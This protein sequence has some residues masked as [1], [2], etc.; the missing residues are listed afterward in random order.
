MKNNQSSNNTVFTKEE[1]E[2]IHK[3]NDKLNNYEYV[4]KNISEENYFNIIQTG[5]EIYKFSVIL[6][7]KKC[8]VTDRFDSQTLFGTDVPFEYQFKFD[9]IKNIGDRINKNHK[10]AFKQIYE[11]LECFDCFLTWFENYSKNKFNREIKIKNCH[12][13]IQSFLKPQTSKQDIIYINKI[14]NSLQNLKEYIDLMPNGNY[15]LPVIEGYRLLELMIEFYLKKEGYSVTDGFVQE[16]NYKLPI[17]QFCNKKNIFPRDFQSYFTL[18]Y[19]YRNEFVHLN[20]TC[21]LSLEFLKALNYIILWFNNTFTEK[22]HI[23]KPFNIYDC[24]FKISSLPKSYED[25]ITKPL[26]KKIND[27]KL[28]VNN[29]KKVFYC[30]G[31]SKNEQIYY[32]DNDELLIE[33][34]TEKIDKMQLQLDNLERKNSNME[35]QINKMELQINN[36]TYQINTCQSLIEKQINNAVSEDE[37]DRLI[38]A[39]VDECSNKILKFT[40][41][42]TEEKTYEIEKR[43]L[44]G[45]LGKNAWNKMSDNSKSFLISSKI[46]YNELI[47]IDEIIDYSGVCIL[48]TKALEFEIFKRF[49]TNFLNYLNENYNHDYSQY[50]TALLYRNTEPLYYEKFTMGSIAF[51]MCYKENIYDTSIQKENNKKILLEYCKSC[52][53]PKYD[54][55]KIKQILEQYAS[56]IEEIRIKYRNPSAHRNKIERITAE[57]CMDL[58]IDVEKLLKIM[59][60]SFDN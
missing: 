51:V 50:H 2:Y 49:Y 10:I 38:K 58:I 13:I 21:D 12:T 39:Y 20:P 18:I 11:F 45:S 8:N 24:Y 4:L 5:T 25:Y 41:K 29:P 14:N 34:L 23:Y 1:V 56:S 55:G 59:L 42:N 26:I 15:G 6:I 53:F 60:D 7:Q 40:E 47:L 36:I 43:K 35:K 44:I 54:D 32:S 57:E 17:I 46:M 16:N 19:K 52:I 27:A 48:L 31:I 37:I 22:F 3:I 28:D 30:K 9:D 33:S